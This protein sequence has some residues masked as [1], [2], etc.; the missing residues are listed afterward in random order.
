MLAAG[1]GD[2]AAFAALYDR[3]SGPVLRFLWHLGY[4]RDG[5]EDLLQE[6]F[7]RVWRAAPRYEV[8]ARFSTYLFQVARNLWINEREKVRRRPPRVSL[9]APVEGAEGGDGDPLAARLP[10]DGPTPA[11]DAAS[12]ESGRLLRAAVDALP[13]KLRDVFVLGGFEE[14]PYAEVAEVLGI[15]EGTVK[16]RM[17]SAVRE[18]RRRL[19]EEKA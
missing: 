17:W 6:T 8:R 19:G 10:G 2:A 1:R 14:R 18:V 16:S 7:L 13:E 15:P 9:D 4:D 3:W 12:R 5:A 11:E